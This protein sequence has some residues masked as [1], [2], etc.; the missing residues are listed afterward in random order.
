MF[1][2][3]SA[4][5]TALALFVL[6]SY[7]H[8]VDP[9][10]AQQSSAQRWLEVVV[11]SKDLDAEKNLSQTDFQ[12]TEGRNTIPISS[13]A[14]GSAGAV[15]PLLIWFVVQCA[16]KR[17]VSSGSGFMLN[18]T[19]L[20]TPILQ[21][22]PGADTAAVAHWCDDGTF[23]VDLAPTIDRAA[24]AK[25]LHAVL[26]ASP[27]K[28]SDTPGENAL[29]DVIELIPNVSFSS[30]PQ[31][32][33]VLVFLYGDL[34]GMY[35]HKLED[36]LQQVLRCS[37]I[38]YELDNGAI[39]K[40]IRVT[41]DPS[42]FP[43]SRSQVVHYMAEQTGGQVYSTWT[44]KYGENLDRLIADL[45]RRYEIGF[46]PPTLDG[47]RHDIKI[48]LTDEARHK[49]K[50]AELHYAPAYLAASAM[51]QP[52]TA[53]IPS[54]D[55][56]LAQAL[57]SSAQFTDIRFDASGKVP[58]GEQTAQFSLYIDPRSLT[59]QPAENGSS[60]VQAK[61]T[62][63]AAYFSADHAVLSSQVKNFVVTRTQAEESGDSKAVIV[64]FASS[65]PAE[66]VRVRFIL[67]DSAANLGSFELTSARI[68][69]EA[70]PAAKSQ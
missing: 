51:Q 53:S 58:F 3:S 24:P 32:M 50:S 57:S 37:G 64:N 1:R 66:T 23:A 48:K 47:R 42:P 9:V 34:N 12:I 31:A 11:E 52:E 8:I 38:V 2:L 69:R 10:D 20:F 45:H 55:G 41:T 62:L 59:W 63:A 22:L 26:S 40:P 49:L 43:N 21:N 46:V 44:N 14:G 7:L 5:R 56:A 15:R 65:L 25:A 19:D 70:S 4:N 27:A 16:E 6:L 54:P 28:T 39:G 18:K 36:T 35:Q 17:S 60:D 30:Q 67:Q 68:K 29:H 13:F 33:P 61:F